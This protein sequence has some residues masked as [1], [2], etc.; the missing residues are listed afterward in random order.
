METEYI[1]ELYTKPKNK[2]VKMRGGSYAWRCPFCSGH[3]SHYCKSGIVYGANGIAEHFIYRC[4]KDMDR[5]SRGLFMAEII[6]RHNING[7]SKKPVTED[8]QI[9]LG[10]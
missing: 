5:R 7:T 9:G 1:K 3:A 8:N 4:E 6:E 2:I 10:V